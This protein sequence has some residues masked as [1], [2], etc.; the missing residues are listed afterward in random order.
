M[1]ICTS[2]SA[3]ICIW[4]QDRILAHTLA[5]CIGL[6]QMHSL[7]K[8]PRLMYALRGLEMLPVPVKAQLVADA[9]L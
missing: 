9:F 3:C 5:M 7:H 2:I 8:Q 1:A 4:Y 6:L